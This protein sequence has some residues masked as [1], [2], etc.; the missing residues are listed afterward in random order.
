MKKLAYLGFALVL[1]MGVGCALTDYPVITDVQQTKNGQSG[2]INTNGKAHV[3]GDGLIA[4]GGADGVWHSQIWFID[5][6]FAGD[7]T[8]TTYSYAA[9]YYSGLTFHGDLYCNP[10]WEGCAIVTAPNPYLNDFDIYDYTFNAHCEGI[11]FLQYIVSISARYPYYGECGRGMGK[12]NM[13]AF[14]N[15]GR[16]ENNQLVYDVNH[17]N[18]TIL[19]DNKAGFTKAMPFNANATL[20]LNGGVGTA[21]Q[22]RIALNDPMIGT[23]MKDYADFLANNATRSTHVTIMYNGLGFGFDIAGNLGGISS[24]SHVLAKANTYF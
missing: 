3:R 20:R 4:S 21:L 1:A 24:P 14:L 7:Q 6:N 18:T 8:I 15:M 11:Q 16:I 22:G 13:L 19:L 12:A 23:M 9:P 5:Q 10:D 2:I 17:N